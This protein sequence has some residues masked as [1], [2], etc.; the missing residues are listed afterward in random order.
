MRLSLKYLHKFSSN[1]HVQSQKLNL[2]FKGDRTYIH[3]SDIY[4]AV[5]RVVGKDN[6]VCYLSHLAFRRFARRD[7]DLL[8]AKPPQG[9]SLTAQGRVRHSDTDRPFWVVESSEPAAGRYD[10]DEASLVAPAVRDGEEIVLEKRSIYTPIE[11]VIA[12]TK[13]LS[14]E[15]TP[16]IDGKWVFGQLNLSC[17]LPN[18]YSSLTIRRIREVAGRFSLNNIIIDNDDVGNIRFIVGAP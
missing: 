16:D 5:D 4:N 1:P 3:G 10:F 6:D 9:E 11:E 13:R 14:Y 18:D 15:L 17:A 12:L 8:W 2:K 7:C